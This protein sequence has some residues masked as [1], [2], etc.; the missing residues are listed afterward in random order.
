VFKMRRFKVL[1]ALEKEGEKLQVAMSVTYRQ[2]VS[3]SFRGR[4]R[5]PSGLA[6]LVGLSRPNWAG[7]FFLSLCIFLFSFLS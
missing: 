6:G 2:S 5:P 1:N 7:S 3:C 4:R